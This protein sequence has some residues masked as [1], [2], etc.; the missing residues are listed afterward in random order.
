MLKELCKPLA[1]KCWLIHI[2]EAKLQLCYTDTRA[3]VMQT[4][5]Q[6]TLNFSLFALLPQQLSL[7]GIIK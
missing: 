4:L 3:D 7:T 5:L 1:V 2:K 6:L